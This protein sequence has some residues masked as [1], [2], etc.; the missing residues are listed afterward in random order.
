MPEVRGHGATVDPAEVAR[1]EA[2]AEEWWDA[3]G[4]F[5]PLHRL[6]PTRLAYVRDTL[7]RHFGRDRRQPRSLAGLRVLDIGCG[8]GL[9]SEPLA[10]LGAAV[11]GI[12][13]A[14]ETIAAARRHAEAQDLAIDYRAVRV[15]DIA[16]AGETFDAVLALEVVEHV[17]DVPSFLSMCADTIRPGGVLILATLNRT[18]K[19][20]ALAIVGA[21]YLLRWL[22]IGTHRWE[23][24]VTP[25]EL[26]R[27][28]K[29][30]GLR[31]GDVTGV[32]YSPLLDEWRLAS[33][34]DVNYI[35]TAVK[36]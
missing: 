21:E 12:D 25:E 14:V 30:A 3:D 8:G 22:P 31:P 36:P 11:T 24:F 32:V 23:R 13:P 1:F 26:R 35:A 18:L 9:M 29:Q 17:P 15:E 10:R 2:L 16:A 33:D 19:S 34:T 5:A 7:C 27:A 20:F 4:K 6:N 28:L